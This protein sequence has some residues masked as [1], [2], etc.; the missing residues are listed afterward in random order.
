MHER[1]PVTF[2]TILRRPLHRGVARHRI[3]AIDFFEMKIRKSSDQP[4]NASSGGLHLDRHGNRVAVILDAED[5]RQLAQRRRV[6]RLPEL[7]FARRAIAQ[8]DVGYFVALKRDVLELAVVG[9][10]LR[11]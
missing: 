2:P 9:D 7:A 10:I 5:H 6:H 8:R 1:R 3:G 11:I 4:R